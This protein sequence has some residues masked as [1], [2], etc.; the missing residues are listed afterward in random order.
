V[1]RDKEA[2]EREATAEKVPR[3]ALRRQ[4]Q[5]DD[6]E[7]KTSLVYT[8]SSRPVELLGRGIHTFNPSTQEAEA[9]G[10]YEFKVSLVCRESS[11]TARATLRD[12]VSKNK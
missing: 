8:I 4:R 6:F 5:E 3:Q 9:V 2:P 10:L 1:K 12:P 11:R 7:F